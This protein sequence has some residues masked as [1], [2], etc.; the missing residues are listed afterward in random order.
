MSQLLELSD[1]RITQ[2]AI[3]ANDSVKTIFSLYIT[4]THPHSLVNKCVYP[5]RCVRATLTLQVAVR[6]QMA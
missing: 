3:V 1:T 6:V 4:I 2:V 5:T